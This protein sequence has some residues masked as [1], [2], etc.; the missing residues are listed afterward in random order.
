MLF[1]FNFE[2]KYIF[3]T[4]FNPNLFSVTKV[5]VPFMTKESFNL[6]VFLS[7]EL[8]NINTSRTN[9]YSIKEIMLFL[10]FDEQMFMEA[11]NNL[12]SLELLKTYISNE[13]EIFFE[14]F[15]PLKIESFLE[16]KKFSKEL[17]NLIGSET[18]DK[19]KKQFCSNVF[20][21]NLKNIS[22]KKID[23]NSSKEKSINEFDFERLNK[24]INS[25]SPMEIEISEDVKTDIS[26][27]YKEY[28][29]SSSDVENSIYDSI[30]KK[31]NNFIICDKKMFEN[32]W[33]LTLANIDNM[34]NN[35]D[36]L[37][38]R[39]IFLEN[40]CNDEINTSFLIYKNF[41]TPQFFT[42]LTREIISKNNYEIIDT[43]RRKYNLSDDLINM[44]INF[45]LRRT[46]GNLNKKYLLKM[47]KTF[48]LNNVNDLYFAYDFL[49]NWE[50]K[51]SYKK[52]EKINL[53]VKKNKVVSEEFSSQNQIK[54]NVVI[55]NIDTYL[56]ENIDDDICV[57]IDHLNL[58]G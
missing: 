15:E 55:T 23:V 31:E 53:A 49:S 12:E 40:L 41:S 46:Y 50:N 29:I 28:K 1:D 3:K 33:N 42:F 35:N 20:L 21:K 19:L 39:R 27:F 24:N 11:K 22:L 30:E 37:I 18:F 25:V 32:M 57:N 8:K 13:N 16:N 36:L 6:Y 51:S 2:Y 58:F 56:D 45:S 44:M 17:K 14:L 43:L 38:C 7:E 5:Y 48:N 4:D 34:H 47:A 52:S 10:G 9:S 54:Q 26:F